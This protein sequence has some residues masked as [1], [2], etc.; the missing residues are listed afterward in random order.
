MRIAALADAPLGRT[1]LPITDA[2]TGVNRRELDFELSFARAVDAA[3]AEQPDVLLL[4]GDV[5]DHPRPTYRAFRVAARELRKV[6]E[7]P[8]S[9]CCRPR[10]PAR[11]R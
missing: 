5:F 10:R 4:L 3:L 8:R 11:C 1:Y 6:R 9:A 2:D 7:P